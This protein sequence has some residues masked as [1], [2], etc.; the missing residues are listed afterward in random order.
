MR[1]FFFRSYMST[2]R[3][4]SFGFWVS[5][6]LDVPYI[7]GIVFVWYPF[8]HKFNVPYI[9]SSRIKFAIKKN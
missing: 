4:G 1:A 9:Y 7:C 3:S 5:L 6:G 8:Y 2:S